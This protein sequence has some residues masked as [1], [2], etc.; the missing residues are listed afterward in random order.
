MISCCV[1]VL[2]ILAGAVRFFFVMKR[3]AATHEKTPD[4]NPAAR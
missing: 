4:E 1:T 3:L 2:G